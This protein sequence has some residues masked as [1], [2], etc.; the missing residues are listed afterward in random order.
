M[1]VADAGLADTIVARA[2]AAGGGARA[3][4]R[5]SGAGAIRVAERVFTGTG[6]GTK[7]RDAPAARSAAGSIA[8]DDVTVPAFALVWR[9][10]RSFTGED[11][12][13]L[14]VVSSPP[15]I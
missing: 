7:L 5:I 12:V 15:L 6:T 11:L 9:A 14:H 8:L 4:V 3:I 10:P 2:T 13:E 1:F